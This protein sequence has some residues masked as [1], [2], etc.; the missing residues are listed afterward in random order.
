MIEPPRGEYAMSLQILIKVTDHAVEVQRV[1]DG[2]AGREDGNQTIAVF[3]LDSSTEA[4]NR[5][6]S[7]TSAARAPRGARRRSRSQ[8]PA[9][10]SDFVNVEHRHP[11]VTG[12]RGGYI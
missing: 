1:I 12:F 8:P 3:S 2:G 9:S 5:S 10:A 7:D 11:K 4:E 6:E